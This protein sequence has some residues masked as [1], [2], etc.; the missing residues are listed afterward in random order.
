MTSREQ[1]SR[2]S[3]GW[4]W[5]A[6][7]AAFVLALLMIVAATQLHA[8]TFTVLHSFGQYPDGYEPLAG[9]TMD[10]HGNLYGITTFGGRGS[11]I[12]FKLAPHA[13]NWIYSKLYDFNATSGYIP[14]AKLAIGRDGSLYGTATQGGAYEYDGTV[15]N[16]R[17]SPTVCRA[18]AC[19][20]QATVIHNFDGYDGSYP[21][22][23]NFDSSGNILGTTFQGGA[24]G[25]GVVYTLVPS[26]GSWN[27]SVLSDFSGSQVSE[28][29]GG[30]IAD[31]DGNL[32]G[33]AL[34]AYPGTVF[35]LTTSGAANIL[36]QFGPGGG[37]G[38][39]PSTG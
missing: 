27:F 11:G 38:W 4:D 32:Y 24:V 3:R 19:P 23:M 2:M 9:V 31:Q 13:G 5:W 39:I 35:Q 30:V 18:T 20:W 25:A 8:Q 21:T 22:T 34:G 10:S 26:N 6:T 16:L 29:N 17:P 14:V 15:F 33:T 28:P 1:E 36:H 12:A 37:T 7:V